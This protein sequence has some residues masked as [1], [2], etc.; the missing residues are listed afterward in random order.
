MTT[1]LGLQQFVWMRFWV[2]TVLLMVS[3]PS[4]SACWPVDW[5]MVRTEQIAMQRFPGMQGAMP[6]VVVCQALNF[7]NRA[8]G[9]RF[10]SGP[11]PTIEIP[12]YSLNND[13]NNIL[14]HELGHAEANR[15][16]VDDRSLDGHGVGWM[17]VMIQAGLEAE[18]QRVADY[19]PAAA[20]AFNVARQQ[21]YGQTAQQWNPQDGGPQSG[22][23][24]YTQCYVQQQFWLFEGRHRRLITQWA[25][26]WCHR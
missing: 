6:K 17:R 4:W 9:G 2:T 19:M 14:A 26:A 20:H 21:V 7:P 23:G 16:G 8:I 11:V 12:E 1:H 18:A 3:T 5:V 24:G 22:P 13:L 25:L 10:N 15:L